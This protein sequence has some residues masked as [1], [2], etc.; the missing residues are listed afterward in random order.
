[1]EEKWYNA[2]ESV[3]TE[4]PS[5]FDPMLCVIPNPNS[6]GQ[7][8]RCTFSD[9]EQVGQIRVFDLSGRLVYSEKVTGDQEWRIDR[10]LAAGL[11]NIVFFQ[12]NQPVAAQKI[13]V[14]E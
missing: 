6:P 13:V 3:P 2:G 14:V 5:G 8:I 12:Q 4:A 10:H 7:S 9:P 1:M 11:Y